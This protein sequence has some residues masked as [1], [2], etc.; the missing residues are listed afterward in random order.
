[1]KLSCTWFWLLLGYFYIS[2]LTWNFL[3][4]LLLPYMAAANYISD[5][6]VSYTCYCKTLIKPYHFLHLWIF[7]MT[8]TVSFTSPSHIYICLLPTPLPMLPTSSCWG[9]FFF[10]TNLKSLWVFVSIPKFQY[11]K[12]FHLPVVSPYILP[13]SSFRIFCSCINYMKTDST[14]LVFH[15]CNCRPPGAVSVYYTACHHHWL[16]LFPDR[17]VAA[18]NVVVGISCIRNYWYTTIPILY[19]CLPLPLQPLHI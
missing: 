18:T 16:M 8:G 14:S 17:S 3:H 19:I 11:F 9:S 1:M 12:N 13:P 2:N 6:Q 4:P 10:A 5:T 7:H 15:C